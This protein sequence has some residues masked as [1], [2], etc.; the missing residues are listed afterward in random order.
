[1]AAFAT[2]TA[3]AQE[4]DTSKRTVG[5]GRKTEADEERAVSQA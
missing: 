5:R 3:Q 1:M 2:T 4:R